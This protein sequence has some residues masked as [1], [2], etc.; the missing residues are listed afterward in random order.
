[1]F[2]S[3]KISDTTTVLL[4]AQAG[5]AFAKNDL[6]ELPDPDTALLRLIDM[7]G[8]VG[9]QVATAVGGKMAGSGLSYEVEF[10][11]RAD[12]MGTVMIAMQPNEGQVKV[13][14]IGKS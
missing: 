6:E 14:I 12:G 4:E 13:R 11:V 1:M 10:S 7:V 2:Y 3:T 9:K 8:D 5:G